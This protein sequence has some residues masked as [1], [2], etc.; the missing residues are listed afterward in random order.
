MIVLRNVG[1]EPDLLARNA[2]IE[3]F[4]VMAR[5]L[6]ATLAGVKMLILNVACIR[7]RRIAWVR[8][9]CFLSDTNY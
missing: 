8:G 4:V 3:K 1:G 9:R 6:C 7:M 2:G 5:L